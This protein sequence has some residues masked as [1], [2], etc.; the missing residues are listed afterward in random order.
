MISKYLEAS[1]LAF[2]QGFSEFIPVS[3]TGHLIIAADLLSFSNNSSQ[4]FEIFIQL[5]AILAVVIEYRKKISSTFVDLHSSKI[6]QNFTLHLIIAFIPAALLGFLFHDL[7]KYFL[8]NPTTVAIALITGGIVI[9]LIEKLL[10]ERKIITVDHISKYQALFIGLAQCL[11]LVPGVSRAGATIM[12]GL[13]AGLDRKTS[14]EFSFFLAIPI[15]VAASL[16]DLSQNFHLLN[17]S[18]LIIFT[19]GFVTAFISALLI[20]KI[21]I[22]FVANHNFIIFGWYRI[23]IGIITLWYFY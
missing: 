22:H 13:I 21:F 9:I 1:I 3:S 16:F 4:V 15:I 5:G 18:D 10:P 11:S 7:I 14:T 20:I 17:K 8:F 2:I 19:T 12:G 6:A 23:L